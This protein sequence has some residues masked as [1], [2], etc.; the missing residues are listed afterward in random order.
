MVFLVLNYALCIPVLLLVGMFSLYHF[1]CLSINTTTIESWEKDKVATMIRRG[2]I[3]EVRLYF[4][5]PSVSHCTF[6]QCTDTRP[7]LFEFR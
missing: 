2:K 3:R 6:E 5:S 1:Y 7:A 4:Q